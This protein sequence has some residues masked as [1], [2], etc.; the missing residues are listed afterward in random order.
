MSK[1]KGF[2]KPPVAKSVFVSDL[3]KKVALR[4]LQPSINIASL[5]VQSLEEAAQNELFAA[6]NQKSQ[7]EDIV[8][9]VI[10]LA[11]L[12]Q[13][14]VQVQ[15]HEEDVITWLSHFQVLISSVQ[16]VNKGLIEVTHFPPIHK[17]EKFGTRL[18]QKGEIV[19]KLIE[20]A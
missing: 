19:A 9:L 14:G 7:R 16:L 11:S 8:A 20:G 1:F 18:T 13:G 12:E 5:W 17:A 6:V 15:F 2:G 10:F 4:Q 3:K